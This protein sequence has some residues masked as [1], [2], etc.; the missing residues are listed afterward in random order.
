[1]DARGRGPVE[2]RAGSAGQFD[3]VIGGKLVYSRHV[4]GRFPTPTDLAAMPSPDSA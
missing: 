1:M 3:I 4:T 2:V